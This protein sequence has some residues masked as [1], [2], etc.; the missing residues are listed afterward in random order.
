M[1]KVIS[2]SEGDTK[3]A[4]GDFP[5]VFII[6][7]AISDIRKSFPSRESLS[8]WWY[9]LAGINFL[10]TIIDLNY[11]ELLLKLCL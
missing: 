5:K 1:V 6:A 7:E 11:F 8:G 4:L 3:S 2:C 10:L 9:A